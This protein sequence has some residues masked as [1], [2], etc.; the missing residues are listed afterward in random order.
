MEESKL[1]KKAIVLSLLFLCV[2]GL[3]G[4]QSENEKNGTKGAET[5]KTEN[6]AE[7][8]SMETLVAD[9]EDAI[10]SG[11]SELTCVYKGKAEELN[12]RVNEELPDQ[13]EKSYLC[14]NLLEHVDT[15]WQQDGKNAKADFTLTYQEDVELP[16]EVANSQEEVL[17]ILI[18]DWEERG[19][20]ITILLNGFT[21]TED[22]L[23]ALLD[24]AEMNSTM[25]PCEAATV[26]YQAYDPEE[27]TDAKESS[28]PESAETKSGTDMESSEKNK[29]Q[30]S[31][32][33]VRM[34]L[35]FET[36][37]EELAEKKEELKTAAESIGREIL[38]SA[39]E[40]DSKDSGNSAE[41]TVKKSQ[42]D[43]NDSQV[44]ENQEEKQEESKKPAVPDRILYEKIYDKILELAEYD[45]SIAT[46]TY[47]S[48]LSL[49]MRIQRSAYGALVDGHTVCTG[50]ARGFEA[51][52]KE[53][54]LPCWVVS[55]TRDGVRHTWN[56]VKAD[57]ELFYVDCTSGDTG[58]DKDQAFLFTKEQMDA[59]GYIMDGNFIIPEI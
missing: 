18:R 39:E 33:I 29:A 34:W 38:T 26:C 7:E 49:N 43:L 24:D 3:T 1:K 48:R 53:L 52:C 42:N 31:R 41:D 28:D 11:E 30:G 19:G 14:R 22:E 5:T 9:L 57:G 21:P 12:E 58:A 10:L 55:G 45:D 16:V 35:D 13:M 44:S 2:F 56:L 23:F 4:C 20:K 50:Y 27:S 47:A 6:Q 40:T 37:E 25:L 36:P 8:L 15:T 59:N 54:N 17:D 32:Q 46:M 51:L